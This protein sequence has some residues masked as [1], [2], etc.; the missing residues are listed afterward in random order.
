VEYYIVDN[1]GGGRP[2]GELKGT[3]TSDGGTYDIYQT[4][5]TNAPSIRGTATFPQFWSVRQ[6]PR[7]G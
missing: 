1:W 7:T 4:T 6:S 5:R 2:S 3:V